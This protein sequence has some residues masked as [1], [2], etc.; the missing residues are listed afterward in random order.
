MRIRAENQIFKKRNKGNTSWFFEKVN[1][2]DKPPNGLIRNKERHK[3]QTNIRNDRGDIT[4]HPTDMKKIIRDCNEKLYGNKF[5]NLDEMDK[6]FEKYKI[7]GL[8][9]WH[10]G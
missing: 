8:P 6:I 10:S 7:L 3:L 2:F 4:I 9:W 5:N 1:K